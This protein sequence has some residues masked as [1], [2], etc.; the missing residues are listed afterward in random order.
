MANEFEVTRVLR[1]GGERR[2]P[3]DVI[4]ETPDNSAQLRRILQYGRVR[5]LKDRPPPPPTRGE[6]TPEKATEGV[7]LADMTA[8]DIAAAVRDGSL[9]RDEVREYETGRSR[10]RKTVLAALDD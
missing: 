8:N 7:S 10:P 5:L 4:T 3:G 1:I 9:D 2:F 6:G